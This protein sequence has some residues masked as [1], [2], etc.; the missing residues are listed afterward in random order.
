MH[1][2]LLK[3]SIL[4]NQAV[5]LLNEGRCVDAVKRLTASLHIV[6]NLMCTSSFLDED[7]NQGNDVLD[8]Q[9]EIQYPR[10]R[11]NNV[12]FCAPHDRFR[13]RQ[14]SSQGES[15]LGLSQE[16]TTTPQ[17][18]HHK[19]LPSQDVTMDEHSFDPHCCDLDHPLEI[20]IYDSPLQICPSALAYREIRP[21]L[22][23]EFSVALMF[24]LALCH[25][26]RAIQVDKSPKTSV[27]EESAKLI[28]QQAVCLYELSY[29]VQMQEDVELSVESTMAIVNNLGHIHQRLGNPEKASKCFMHLLSTFLFIQSSSV[30]CE[31]DDDVELSESSREGFLRSVS[32]IILSQKVAPAA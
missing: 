4:N 30:G 17:H 31:V 3:A 26:L 7:V 19:D 27:E 28:F 11:N 24:N 23:S 5:D 12:V 14:L 32:S 22:L 16:N 20:F 15:S 6:K 8:S 9:G 10:K 25:H 18:E 2:Q 13:C 21:E 1:Q 29:E